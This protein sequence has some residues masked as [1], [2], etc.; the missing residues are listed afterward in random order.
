VNR[1]DFQALT[2]IRLAEAQMLLDAGLYDGAYYLSGYAVECALKACIARKTRIHDFPP[3]VSEVRDMYTHKAAD[4]VRAA[5]LSD[6]LADRI[7][8]CAT[9]SEHWSIVRLWSEESRYQ[10]WSAKEARA[11]FTAVT[12]PQ[13]GVLRWVREHW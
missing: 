8:S 7:R 12:D 5:D 6:S 1:R 3:K 9:F 13:H 11:V 4:L 10:R 2:T